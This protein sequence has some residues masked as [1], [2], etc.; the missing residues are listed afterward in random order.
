MSTSL[1]QGLKELLNELEEYAP[2]VSRSECTAVP[3]ERRCRQLRRA[4]PAAALL[5]PCQPP[6]RTGAG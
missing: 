4:P 2:A 3:Q 5:T 6:P 1:P